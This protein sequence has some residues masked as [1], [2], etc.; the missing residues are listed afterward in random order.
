MLLV[1]CLKMD[2]LS[3]KK[4]NIRHEPVIKNPD[5]ESRLIVIGFFL[6]G[7]I[8]PERD[9]D[10]LFLSCTDWRC[11]KFT[12]MPLYILTNTGES[13]GSYVST[14]LSSNFLLHLFTN[15]R[16]LNMFTVR[17][18]VCS[19]EIHKINFLLF[20]MF[21]DRLCLRHS[22]SPFPPLNYTT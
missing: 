15:R 9:T 14:D 6:R 12:T 20:G 2:K 21:I 18:K 17:V 4:N 11:V 22:F 19:M 10:H 8:S 5:T 1:L 16:C 3:T 7:Q 13:L